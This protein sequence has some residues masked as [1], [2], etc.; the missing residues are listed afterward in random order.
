MVRQPIDLRSQAERDH[1]ETGRRRSTQANHLH[2]R[3][4]ELDLFG[5]GV[6]D[7][8]NRPILAEMGAYAD[9]VVS[10]EA[11]G[12]CLSLYA[13]RDDKQT[14]AGKRGPNEIRK[15]VQPSY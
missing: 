14:Q 2:M 4:A 7:L 10:S 1:P 9:T 6:H 11:L 15:P 8:L 12:N 5:R 3:I 13:R